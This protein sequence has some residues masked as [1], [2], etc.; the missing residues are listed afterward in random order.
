M[1]DEEEVAILAAEVDR[2]NAQLAQREPPGVWGRLVLWWRRQF[3]VLCYAGPNTCGHCK[4]WKAPRPRP[5][6]LRCGV[7]YHDG[8]YCHKDW[9]WAIKSPSKGD[10]RLLYGK[11]DTESGDTCARFWPRRR[12]MHRAKGSR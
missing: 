8:H 10:C 4:Y 12:Y 9:H 3:G 6:K 7:R 11:Q 1:S 5:V 2:L